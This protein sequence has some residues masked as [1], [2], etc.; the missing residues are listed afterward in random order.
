[1]LI[2]PIPY[3]N[4]I[5][6][7]NLDMASYKHCSPF[8]LWIVNKSS[9]ANGWAEKKNR[10]R[11]LIPARR[12]GERERRIHHKESPEDTKGTQPE[13][14]DTKMHLHLEDLGWEVARLAWRIKIDRWL[15][16]YCSKAWL[17]KSW[18]LGAVIGELARIKKNSY[19]I[20]LFIYLY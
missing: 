10:A 1:M 8:I 4:P 17:N 12:Q 18:F 2:T 13:Q 6:C 11:L 14:T 3:S 20:D 9:S 7:C 15:P 19:C 5:I 16:R